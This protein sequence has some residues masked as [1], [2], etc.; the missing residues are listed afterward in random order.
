MNPS[1]AS[2]ENPSEKAF[3]DLGIFTE[4]LQG[5]RYCTYI[6]I[7]VLCSLSP[8]FSHKVSLLLT[9]TSALM[10]LDSFLL[11]HPHN[12]HRPTPVSPAPGSALKA[13]TLP[14]LSAQLSAKSARE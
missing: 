5:P 1:Q 2:A 14:S 9:L 7:V 13:Q 10:V 12:L 11:P 6:S 4:A 8:D 3:T